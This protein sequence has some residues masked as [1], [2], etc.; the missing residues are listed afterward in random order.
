MVPAQDKG[1]GQEGLLWRDYMQGPR[2]RLARV[3]ALPLFFPS[4]TS[5][6][7]LVT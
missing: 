6:A 7:Q 4:Y 2:V 1:K 5:I 3:Q